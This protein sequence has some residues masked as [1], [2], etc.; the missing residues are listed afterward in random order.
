MVFNVENV[1]VSDV[2]MQKEGTPSVYIVC[3]D[4]G[5]YGIRILGGMCTTVELSEKSEIRLY[6]SISSE[7][8]EKIKR[9]VY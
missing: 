3:V 6:M 8:S 2:A 1:Y 7:G 9:R 4:M 5:D